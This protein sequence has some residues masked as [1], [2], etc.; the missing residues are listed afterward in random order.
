MEHELAET[1]ERGALRAALRDGSRDGLAR[2]LELVDARLA[3]VIRGEQAQRNARALEHVELV[4]R[5]LLERRD[6]DGD[7]LE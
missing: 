3:R 4:T 1:C 7:I 5:E 2:E 6:V